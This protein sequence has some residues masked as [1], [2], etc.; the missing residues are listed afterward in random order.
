MNGRKATCNI[1]VDGNVVFISKKHK[2]SLMEIKH[3]NP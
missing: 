2:I 3:G 1:S